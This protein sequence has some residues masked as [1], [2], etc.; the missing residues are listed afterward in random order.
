MND[1]AK[2]LNIFPSKDKTYW[3]FNNSSLSTMM[4]ELIQ[5]YLESVSIYI[6]CNRTTISRY[7]DRDNYINIHDY[8]RY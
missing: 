6:L 3:N 4:A 8:T 1:F 5:F 2:D 7:K